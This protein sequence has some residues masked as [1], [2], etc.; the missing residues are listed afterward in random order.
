MPSG[1]CTR[2]QI[3]TSPDG[4]VRLQNGLSCLKTAL[5]QVSAPKTGFSGVKVLTLSGSTGEDL[6]RAG[7]PPTVLNIVHNCALNSWEPSVSTKFY[8]IR[9]A[10]MDPHC[11]CIL[12]NL[13]Y[14]N[15]Y[16]VLKNSLFRYEFI[17]S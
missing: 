1:L 7:I 16:S 14:G 8:H 3:S 5:A 9:N 4:A 12:G 17:I 6:R 13:A 15:T 2:H 10:W 11:R